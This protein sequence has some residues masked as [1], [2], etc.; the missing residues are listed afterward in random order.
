MALICCMYM[1]HDHSL[2]GIQ[3]NR[4]RS[5]IRVRTL[6]L[7]Q[8]QSV[9]WCLSEFRCMYE[10]KVCFRVWYWCCCQ[11]PDGQQMYVGI[12]HLGIVTFQGNKRTHQ[13][14]WYVLLVLIIYYWLFWFCFL[15]AGTSES[16]HRAAY[17]LSDRLVGWFRLR[18]LST[19]IRLYDCTLKK[20]KTYPY[21]CYYQRCDM[22]LKFECCT[23]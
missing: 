15:S 6:I 3:G 5:G 18:A 17:F 4:S 20:S 1:G 22:Y 10:K 13:F 2:T 16:W 12:T 7:D 19:Q 21:L 9:F 23:T 8:R 14:K 11:D